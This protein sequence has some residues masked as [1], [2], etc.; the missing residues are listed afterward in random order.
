MT[1][2]SLQLGT[3]CGRH[4]ARSAAAGFGWEPQIDRRDAARSLDL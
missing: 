2:G 4:G 1:S 3:G